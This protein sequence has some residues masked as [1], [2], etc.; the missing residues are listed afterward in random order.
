EPHDRSWWQ[1]LWLLAKGHTCAECAELAETTGCP[2][3]PNA[4][5]AST[6]LATHR[7]HSRYLPLHL[8]PRLA[9]RPLLH[10]TAPASAYQPPIPPESE[11]TLSTLP[12]TPRVFVSHH[13]SPEE[14]R[15]TA[16]LVADL[17]AAGAD[18]W[19]DGKGITSDDFVQKISEGLTGR[20]WLVLIM[21]L[22]ALRSPWV[23]REVNAALNEQTAGRMLGVLPLVMRPCAEN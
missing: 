16:Q 23:R 6:A 13:H 4:L 1:I 7:T 22:E 3:S 19:V 9:R 5:R 2:E 18:V 11:H 15:F 20:Q 8:H 10:Y 14:D 21:T 17:E 12:P